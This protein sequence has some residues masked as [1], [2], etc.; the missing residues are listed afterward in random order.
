MLEERNPARF[1]PGRRGAKV[2]ASRAPRF[3]AVARTE[4]K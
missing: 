2:V 3:D 4:V 1:S